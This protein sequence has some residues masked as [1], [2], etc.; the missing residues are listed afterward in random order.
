MGSA[1]LFTAFE[2]LISFCEDR[3][4]DSYWIGCPGVAD[5]WSDGDK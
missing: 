3:N 5:R 1:Q 4:I 2:M